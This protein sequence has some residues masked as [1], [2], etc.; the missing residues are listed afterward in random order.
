MML[1]VIS[2]DSESGDGLRYASPILRWRTNA[3]VG[4]GEA[5]CAVTHR[6]VSFGLIQMGC[7]V[8]HPSYN[9]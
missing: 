5:L 2:E 9:L 6:V 4:W 8:L 7:V 3:H 1:S